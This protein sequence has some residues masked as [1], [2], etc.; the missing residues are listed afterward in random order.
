[1]AREHE[2]TPARFTPAM[3]A[4]REHGQA[5][6]PVNTGNVDREHV[7]TACQHGSSEPTLKLKPCSIACY[8]IQQRNGSGT[9]D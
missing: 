3:Y 9:R 5:I 8:V 1:M 2:Y 6:R 7:F 4:A